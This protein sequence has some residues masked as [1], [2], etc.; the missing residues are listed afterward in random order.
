MIG[1]FAIC[2]AVVLMMFIIWRQAFE[3]AHFRIS[4]L[5]TIIYIVLQAASIG[6]GVLFY[7]LVGGLKIDL[8]LTTFI[9]VPIIVVSFMAFY[10]IWQDNDYCVYESKEG[11]S[12][13]LFVRDQTISFCG[14]LQKVNWKPKTRQDWLVAILLL[15]NFGTIIVYTIV[16][17][18]YFKPKYVGFTVGVWIVMIELMIFL[19]RKYQQNNYSFK[20]FEAILCLIG[21]ATVFLTWIC[22]M[23]L[24]ILNKDENKVL[25][26]LTTVCSVIYFLGAII[27]LLISELDSKGTELKKLSKSFYVQAGSLLLLMV[28]IG[29]YLLM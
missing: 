25:W 19:A 26:S 13:D 12:L 6:L 2:I 8:I 15:V 18:M 24:K 10:G 21:I 14:R 27:G 29:L 16:T 20:Q 22:V 9:L 23:L 3:M 1:V 7:W 17:M 4:F 28:A 5:N 11:G